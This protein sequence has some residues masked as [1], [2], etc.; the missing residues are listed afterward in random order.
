MKKEQSR[1]KKA[2]ATKKPR[3]YNETHNLASFNLQKTRH[4]YKCGVHTNIDLY[5]R[6]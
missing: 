4:D 3:T 6:I 5:E 2:K 1:Q